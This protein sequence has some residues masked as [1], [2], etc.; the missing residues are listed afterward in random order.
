M[1]I[2]EGG[3]IYSPTVRQ[4]IQQTFDSCGILK[5]LVMDAT[6]KKAPKDV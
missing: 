1:H 3:Q 5:P 6:V 4:I 2:I